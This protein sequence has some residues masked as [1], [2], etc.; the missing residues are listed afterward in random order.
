[1][2]IDG[3]N[4]ILGRLASFAAKKLLS[5]ESVNIVNAEKIIITGN[6][7]KIVGEYLKKRRKGSPQHGPF[8]PRRPDLIVRRTIRGMLPKT[9]KGRVAFKVLRVYIGVPEVLKNEKF[10][11][12]AIKDIKVDYITIGRVAKSL[13]W[14]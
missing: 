7:K 1:M 8:F 6:P 11:S 3:T 10:E 14:K 12:V 9:N 13:G 5:G 2:N 4:A